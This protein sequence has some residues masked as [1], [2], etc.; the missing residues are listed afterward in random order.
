MS[1]EYRYI[2]AYGE[3]VGR[4]HG[5]KIPCQDKAICLQEKGVSAAVLSDGC[6][7]APLSHYGSDLTVKTVARYLIDN[8][9]SLAATGFDE[10]G[11]A[12]IPTRKALVSEIVNKE[13]EFV[14][15]HPEIFIKHR[16]ENMEKYNSVIK[17]HSEDAY[18][19]SLLHAT[20]IFY[21][22]KDGKAILGQIGDGFMGAVIDKKMRILLEEDKIPGAKNATFYPDN[23]YEFA[24]TYP[25]GDDWYMHR[26]FK[27]R[28]VNSGRISGIMLTSDGVESFFDK[29]VKFQK[30]Y[31]KVDILFRRLQEQET[32]EGRQEVI[33]QNYLPRL[34]A[35]S[36]SFDDCS[37]AILVERD[38]VIEEYIAKEY[39]HDDVEETTTKKT[40]EQK[41]P[42]P[43]KEEVTKREPKVENGASPVILN[44][45]EKK[46]LIRV[47]E[48][49]GYDHQKEFELLKGYAFYNGD[50]QYV[51]EYLSLYEK[52]LLRFKAN[53]NSCEREKVGGNK[54]NRE[55]LKRIYNSIRRVDSHIKYGNA[56]NL[57]YVE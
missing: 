51:N 32:F 21:V 38:C 24:L 35:G 34:V 23:I 17:N 53:N 50:K 9:D 39:P 7:S 20:L 30:K 36:P 56:L 4:S 13:L 11:N 28:L 25:E 2:M 1:E 43:T 29:S 10:K 27:I 18:W 5:T 26:A 44:E 33:N 57:V 41:K 14:K 8:F 6:G 19:L 16:D 31:A 37:I 47:K 3:L 48:A 55:R 12:S 52:V 40:E 15:D 42:E 54:E 22:E 49:Y 46:H 45:E